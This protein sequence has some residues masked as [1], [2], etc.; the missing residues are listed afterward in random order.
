MILL[1]IQ[2]AAT[3]SEYII[4]FLFCKDFLGQEKGSKIKN[5]SGAFIYMIVLIL[6]NTLMVPMGIPPVVITALTLIFLT[7]FLFDSGW[8]WKLFASLI[9]FALMGVFETV[10]I[11]VMLWLGNIERYTLFNTEIIFFIVIISRLMLLLTT[12]TIGKLKNKQNSRLSLEYWL[13]IATFPVVSS[14]VL[15]VLF[16]TS[17]QSEQTQATFPMA[18]A[19]LGMLFVNIL[20]F[21]LI[22]IFS[23]KAERE[24]RE[25]G[26]KVRESVLKQNF[27]RQASECGRLEYLLAE[28]ANL[29]HDLKTYKIKLNQHV[30]D[31]N[32]EDAMGTLERVLKLESMQTK[33]YVHTPNSVINA[34]FN[35][36]IQSAKERGITVNL[37][38]IH[39]PR[40]IKL[41]ITDLCVIFG[42]SLENAITAC[43]KVKD[44]E[45]FI[46]ISL[47]YIDN[48]L[49]YKIKNPTDG[50]VTKGERW[51]NSTKT[52][53]GLSGLG[54]SIMDSSVQKYGGTFDARHNGNIFELGFVIVDC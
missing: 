39:F 32:I 12:K 40:E 13:A 46:A 7:F 29:F 3:L 26:Q 37:Q 8:K 27:E 33:G 48:K 28:Q 30:K 5:F 50:N 47:R 17:W 23:D 22:E 16:I 9:F 42:N 2:I 11:V 21:R 35:Y 19:V 20:A 45:K 10:A 6:A 15:Y 49:T 54:M 44:S 14:V 34:I 52:T 38:D 18:L 53:A 41:D 51:F 24:I 4:F 36:H 25:A 43:E 1:S 31:G